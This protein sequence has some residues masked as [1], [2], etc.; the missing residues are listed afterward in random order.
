M[1]RIYI[2]LVIF[3]SLVTASFSQTLIPFKDGERAVFLGNSITDG[4][5]YHSYIWLYY[6]TRFPYMNIQVMNAGIGGDTAYD[7]YKRLDG[8]VFSKNPTTLFVTFG[9]NDSGYMEYNGDNP[10]EFGNQKYQECYKNFQKIEKRLLG[11]PNTKIVMLGGSPYD[12]HAKIQGNT[13]LNGKN[14]V[15]IRIVEFQ[16]KA[17]EK[18]G[19][20]FLDLNETMSDINATFQ[21]Q[22]STFTLCGNDRIHPDND[23]HMVMAYLILKAQG[24][25]GNKVADIEIDANK[26]GSI[27]KSD[28]CEISDVTQNSKE[29]SFTYLANA[30]PY[31]ID[32]VARGWGAK[33]SQSKA[34]KYISFMEEMNQELLKIIGMKK[35]S[36]SLTIDNENVGVWS[37]EEFKNGINLAKETKTPQYQ[38]SLAIMHLNEF[39]WEIERNFRDYAWVQFGFFQEKGLLFA[40]NAKSVEVMDQNLDK[41]LWLRVHRETYSKYMHQAVREAREK[42]MELLISKIYETNKP[43]SRRIKIKKI[44]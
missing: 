38:Q 33:K 20:Q 26:K 22:D 23:G 27:I 6:M 1:K 10:Q 21:K 36:Y 18:H 7:M 41:N 29:L 24:F 12:E 25:V 39:R 19:W 9:M 42:E 37:S 3:A 31:P 13:A 11:L 4:G 44:N 2:A 40:N 43:V 30:L 14:D 5:H 15:M 34:L 8:D 16:R 28:N 17:A 32:T 35:G